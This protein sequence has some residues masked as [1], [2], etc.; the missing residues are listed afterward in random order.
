MDWFNTQLYQ[1]AGYRLVYPQLLE[2]ICLGEFDSD[3]N[4]RLLEVGARETA[5]WLELLD[6]HVLGSSN[7]WVCGQAKTIADYLG[8][9]HTTMLEWIGQS[10]ESYPNVS[11]WLKRCKGPICDRVHEAHDGFVAANRERSFL[12]I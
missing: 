1:S 5:E 2:H 4:T 9:G 11:A 8:A 7:P 12:T 3:S 10:F 6:T